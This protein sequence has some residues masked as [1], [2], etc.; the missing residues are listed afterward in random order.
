M[1]CLEFLKLIFNFALGQYFLCFR[2]VMYAPS[3]CFRIVMYGL[4]Y[5][6]LEV[7]NL[8]LFW[9]YRRLQFRAFMNL[10]RDFGLLN[11]FETGIDYEDF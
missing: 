7:C 9:F 1:Q 8:F 3:L 11:I 10:R 4:C 5:Y 6:M 2:V